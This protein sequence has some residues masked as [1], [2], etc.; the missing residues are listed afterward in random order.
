MVTVKS[1]KLVGDMRLDTFAV[2]RGFS[3]NTRR[4]QRS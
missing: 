3:D 1:K 4:Q 2:A